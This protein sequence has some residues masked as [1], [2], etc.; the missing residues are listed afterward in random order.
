MGPAKGGRELREA[1][2]DFDEGTTVF[3]DG[4]ALTIPDPEHGWNEYRY[5]TTGQSAKGHLLVVVH[6]E[7]DD[8]IRLICVRNSTPSERRSYEKEDQP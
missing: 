7:R 4:L 8:R 6:T 5:V 3:D 2:C 1:R